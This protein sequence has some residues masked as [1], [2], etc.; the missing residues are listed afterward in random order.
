MNVSQQG[1]SLLIVTFQT[2]QNE[3]SDT[4]ILKSQKCQYP[5]IDPF[6]DFAMKYEIWV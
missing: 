3:V 4:E 2:K 5:N 6:D 1:F